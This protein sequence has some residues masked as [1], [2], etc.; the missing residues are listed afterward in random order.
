MVLPVAGTP[1]GDPIVAALEKNDQPSNKT[2]QPDNE[3]D[4]WPVPVVDVH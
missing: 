1:I 3:A 4:R 2:E